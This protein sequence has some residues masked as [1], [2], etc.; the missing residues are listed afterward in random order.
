MRFWRWQLYYR[1]SDLH[2]VAYKTPFFWHI[3]RGYYSLE[4]ESI[5]TDREQSWSVVILTLLRIRTDRQWKE[6]RRLW[7]SACNRYDSRAQQESLSIE[8]NVSWVRMSRT[9]G[10]R[11]LSRRT[12]TYLRRSREM[13]LGANVSHAGRIS[14]VVRSRI[15]DDREKCVMGAN[16]SHDGRISRVVRSRIFDNREKCVMGANISH[17]GPSPDRPSHTV[18]TRVEWVNP[19]QRRRPRRRRLDAG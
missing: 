9:T 6:C 1:A 15:F 5:S 14:R 10:A 17:D 18:L 8:R 13:C 2:A 7:L 12:I 16:V 11:H 19:H 3:V 4:M